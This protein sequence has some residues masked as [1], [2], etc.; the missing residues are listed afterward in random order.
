MKT[1]EKK[2]RFK[3][4]REL[5]QRNLLKASEADEYDRLNLEL[6]FLPTMPNGSVSVVS[7]E[8]EKKVKNIDKRSPFRGWA[9]GKYLCKCSI[10]QDTFAGDKRAY[11]CADCAYGQQSPQ[12]SAAIQKV[13]AT[14][15]K[16]E[17]TEERDTEA[18]VCADILRR[19]E[20]GLRK[21]GVS[22]A[23]N[24]LSLREWLDH[25]YLETLDKAVYLKRAMDEMDTNSLTEEKLKSAFNRW[26][27]VPSGHKW[28]SFKKELGL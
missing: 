14:P 2:K 23:N 5:R 18:S 24:P 19:Q 25:A 21:Y 20:F 15:P 22:V 26:I 17:A 16:V 28:E 6:A 7:Q 1:E 27:G 4:L 11:H 8:E 13:V 3:L 12:E 9:P 10:C